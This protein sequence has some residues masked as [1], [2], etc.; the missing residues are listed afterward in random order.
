MSVRILCEP[1]RR[2]GFAFLG[3]RILGVRQVQSVLCNGDCVVRI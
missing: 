3:V 2:Y 1:T